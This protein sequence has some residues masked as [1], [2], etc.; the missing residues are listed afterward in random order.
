MGPTLALKKRAFDQVTSEV[1]LLLLSNSDNA[2]NLKLGDKIIY[3]NCLA[4]NLV[5]SIGSIGVFF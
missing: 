2:N 3:I 4:Q 5:Q 1:P